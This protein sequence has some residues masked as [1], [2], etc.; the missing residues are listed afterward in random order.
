[1]T[2]ESI[3]LTPSETITSIEATAGNYIKSVTIETSTGRT[4]SWGDSIGNRFRMV[5]PDGA[6]LLGVFGQLDEAIMSLGVCCG[7]RK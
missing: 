3:K 7:V 2:H 4:V 1:V 5:F 6:V